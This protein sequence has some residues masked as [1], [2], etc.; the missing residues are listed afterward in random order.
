MISAKTAIAFDFKISSSNFPTNFELSLL[1]LPCTAFIIII[2]V[3][4]GINYAQVGVIFAKKALTPK[5]E[6]ISP[7]KGFKRMFSSTKLVD[8]AKG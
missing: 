6:K 7:A 1:K 3:A 5:F 2:A 8:L 4:L